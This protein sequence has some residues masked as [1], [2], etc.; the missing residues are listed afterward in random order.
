M[1]A[2]TSVFILRFFTVC[3]IKHHEDLQHKTG[4]CRIFV[5]KCNINEDTIG[6]LKVQRIQ[7]P[8]YQ[9]SQ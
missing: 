2:Q 4:P 3:A 7:L 8:N 6:K 1:N 9:F 5:L